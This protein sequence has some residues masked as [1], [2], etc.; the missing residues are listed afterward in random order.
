MARIVSDFR[1]IPVLPFDA[2]AAVAYADLKTQRTQLAKMDA[3]IAAI[4]LSRDL[5]VLTR[6]DR[7]FGK[8]AGLVI[9]DW[10]VY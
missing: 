4:A 2:N 3:R 5:T 9:E 8:V 10:T 1:L 6:N 7:D